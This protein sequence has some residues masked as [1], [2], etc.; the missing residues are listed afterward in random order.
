MRTK[1]MNM[2]E[3]MTI[4]RNYE[5]M[6]EDDKQFLENCTG[7]NRY[8]LKK[9]LQQNCYYIGNLTIT[10]K[11]QLRRDIDLMAP[12]EKQIV[13]EIN[14]MTIEE[15]I[16]S[17]DESIDE[18]KKNNADLRGFNK[19]WAKRELEFE[20]KFYEENGGFDDPAENFLKLMKYNDQKMD[21]M[22]E[23]AKEMGIHISVGTVMG[24]RHC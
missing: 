24:T 18:Q 13:A 11:K 8:D 22:I 20:R 16:A 5:H 6:S 7:R 15:V 19:E 4:L 14:N 10:Y 21:A 17:L 3:M 9:A 2:K 12:Y 1:K 23:L